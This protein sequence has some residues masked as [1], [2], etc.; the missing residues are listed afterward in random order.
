MSDPVPFEEIEAGRTLETH[1]RT[2]TEADVRNFAGV[3]GDFNPLHVSE[4]ATAETPFGEPIAHGALL[5]AVTT[6]LLWQTRHERPDVVALYGIDSLR[7]TGP[8]TMGTT[9]H[10]ES[11]V[12]ETE[13]RDH[14]VASGVVRNETR[15]VTDD[16]A[17]VLSCEMLTL[18][19]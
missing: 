6:G 1:S 17:V 8:V 16:G 7:F 18:V 13:P 10:V 19:A 11:V 15:L 5:V 4:T 9:V 2:I 12:L 14:P 3:S